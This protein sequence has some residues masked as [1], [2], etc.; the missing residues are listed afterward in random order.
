MRFFV[1]LILFVFTARALISCSIR[2]SSKISESSTKLKQ[3]E[4]VVLEKSETRSEL[5][6]E[7]LELSLKLGMQYLVSVCDAQGKFRYQTHLDP[8]VQFAPKYNILR[9]S[10]SL[11]AMASYLKKIPEESAKQAL[12]RA[13]HYLKKNFIAPIPK[14]PDLLAVW[15]LPEI[16]G[17][18]DPLQVK[19]GGTALGLL[20]LLHVEEISP[21][22]TSLEDLQALGRGIE[23]M[24]KAEGSFYSKYLPQEGVKSDEWNSL[25]YPGE[26]ALALI[27]LYEKDP[28]SHWLESS[29]KAIAFLARLRVSQ[30]S[31]DPDHWA[32][33]AT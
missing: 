10:G 33:L 24:Q 20:A 16:E 30:Q 6:L 25:Y 28:Q 18:G 4:P 13:A 19:L 15:S 9:H 7:S 32:L 1:L 3:Q 5:I 27:S 8:Q 26:A 31:V 11:Y 21:K 14:H 2:H 22:T 12:L 17:D 23:F 29:E